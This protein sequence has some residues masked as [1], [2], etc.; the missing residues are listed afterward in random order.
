MLLLKVQP[1]V[2]LGGFHGCTVFKLLTTYN[3]PMS[4]FIHT[5]L[6]IIA[7]ASTSQA[8]TSYKPVMTPNRQRLYYGSAAAP[9]PP[10]VASS[11][12]SLHT[13]AFSAVPIPASS[14]IH[15]MP[16]SGYAALN[17]FGSLGPPASYKAA[18][19]GA[20]AQT[21]TPQEAMVQI[22]LAEAATSQVSSLLHMLLW[23]VLGFIAVYVAGSQLYKANKRSYKKAASTASDDIIMS[24][25][26]KIRRSDYLLPT[27]AT[28]PESLHSKY[29]GSRIDREAYAY[30]EGG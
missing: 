19:G 7:L 11:L 15:Q 29:A 9:Q 21:S 18:T 26:K 24:G 22:H 16:S 25:P 13:G 6:V 23:T 17:D 8:V 28:I 30:V 10:A 5:V 27:T 3:L 20:S 1:L 4:N 12:A 2:K 14:Q